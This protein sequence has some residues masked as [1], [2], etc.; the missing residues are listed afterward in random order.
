M[1][2]SS[3]RKR[4]NSGCVGVVYT[5]TGSPY[6][7][8][9][10]FD[11]QDSS[12][13]KT[14]HTVSGSDIPTHTIDNTSWESSVAVSP[15][16]NYVLYGG[17]TST[18]V[19]ILP[20]NFITGFG[21][22]VTKA[23]GT[24]GAFD[25]ITSIRF[26]RDEQYIGIT[27]WEWQSLYQ[28]NESGS[29]SNVI[30]NKVWDSQP[31]DSPSGSGIPIY[32][33]SMN[34]FPYSQENRDGSEEVMVLAQGATGSVYKQR[35]TFVDIDTGTKLNGI[36][37]DIASNFG[38][39]Y[40]TPNISPLLSTTS[41]GTY[42]TIVYIG[43]RSLSHS[44]PESYGYDYGYATSDDRTS[45]FPAYSSSNTIEYVMFDPHG[46]MIVAQKDSPYLRLYSQ[47]TSNAT[48]S[49]IA[50]HSGWSGGTINSMAY[51]VDQDILFVA[52]RSAP[53]LTAIK[54][55]KDGF[56]DQYTPS[57]NPGQEVIRISL[58]YENQWKSYN[59]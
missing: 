38:Y 19:S 39:L 51:D 7:G 4:A 41:S 13:W 53:Y 55:E 49:L 37:V 3:N 43:T 10:R 14:K 1:Q 35:I 8:G 12:P 18:E 27:S 17:R 54:M 29:G 42:N 32:N 11:A 9:Y 46:R 31:E 30:G 45:L 34:F 15:G 48:F 33:F 36:E 23:P 57:S 56:G 44:E 40:R 59:S 2:I 26:T 28:W 21:T 50:S 58:A 20:F 22:K 52:S 25:N 5:T 16:N 47:D 6:I 24:T